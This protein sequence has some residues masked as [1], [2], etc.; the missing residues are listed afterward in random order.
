MEA[1]EL[2]CVAMVPTWYPVCSHEGGEGITGVVLSKWDPSLYG[3]PQTPYQR[4]IIKKEW[5]PE[6]TQKP[7]WLEQWFSNCGSQPPWGSCIR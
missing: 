3:G 2:R 1:E 7:N 4:C 5:W 6:E